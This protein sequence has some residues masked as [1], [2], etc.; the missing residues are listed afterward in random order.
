MTY[1]GRHTADGIRLLAHLLMTEARGVDPAA[2]K[3]AGW[4]MPVRGWL[5]VGAALAA[6][7]PRR[8]LALLGDPVPEETYDDLVTRT[9]RTAAVAMDVNWSPGGHVGWALPPQDEAALLQSMDGTHARLTI[10]AKDPG[11]RLPAFLAGRYLPDVL[12]ARA[13]LGSGD[14][15]NAQSAAVVEAVG[16][17]EET[18]EAVRWFDEL[19]QEIAE[20]GLA[21][22]AAYHL[23]VAADIRDRAGQRRQGEMKRREALRLA[24]RAPALAGMSELAAGDAELGVA[25]AS[26]R[27]LIVPAGG[28]ALKRAAKH[29]ARADALFL[30]SGAARGRAA[31]ALRLAH[32]ARLSRKPKLRTAYVDRALALAAVAGDGAY[33]ALLTVH[34]MLDAVEDG[35]TLPVHDADAVRHWASTVGSGSWLRG[36][37][38]LVAEGAGEWARQGHILRGRQADD[39][40]QRLTERRGAPADPERPVTDAV[41]AART[42]TGSLE[43][44]HEA[45]HR[46][47]SLVVADLE[48]DTRMRRMQSEEWE[49]VGADGP[50]PQAADLQITAG[51]VNE[52]LAAA[53]TAELFF[54]AAVGLGDPDLVAAARPRLAGVIGLGARLLG[55]GEVPPPV[56]EALHSSLEGL[57]AG[58]GSTDIVETLY[59]LRRHRSAGL[60]AEADRTAATAGVLVRTGPLSPARCALLVEMGRMAQARTEAAELEARGLLTPLQSAALRLRLREPARAA[61][62][63]RRVG[64]DGTQPDRPWERAAIAAEAS[65]ALGDRRRAAGRAAEAVTA[66]E[67]HR[68]RLG[69]DTLRAASGDDPV[70]ARAYH[71]AMLSQ[72]E[73]PDGKAAAFA[74]AERSRAGFL[75]A[76]QALESVAGQPAAVR[77]VRGWLQAESRWAARFEETAVAL[78][79]GGSGG[80]AQVPEPAVTAD[81]GSRQR[82]ILDAERALSA[83]ESEVRRI[84][85]R[86]LASRR[87]PGAVPDVAAVRSALAPDTVLLQYH[88]LDHDLLCWAVTREGLVAERHERSADDLVATARRF[89]TACA[90]G[91]EV[92]GPGR[93]LSEALLGFCSPLLS[94]YGRIVVVPPAP[95][96]LVPFHALPRAGAVLGVTHEVSYLP[97]AS[98]LTRQGHRLVQPVW[99]EAPALLVGA[100]ATAPE[101]GL[102]H[103]PGTETEVAAIHG[104]LPRSRVVTG[105]AADR[106]RVLE[107]AAGCA[108]LHLATHGDVQELTPYLSRLALAGRDHLGV[109]DLLGPGLAPELIVLSACD[110]GR[111]TATAGGDVLGL[112]RA[113][114][115][116]GARHAV[117]SLWPVDDITGCLVVTYMYRHLVSP[118]RP[119]VGT[120]LARAQR[121]VRRLSPDGREE[122]Y[123]RLADRVHVGSDPSGPCVRSRDSGPRPSAAGTDRLHPFHWAPFIHVGV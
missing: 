29:Y 53:S 11:L 2:V 73:L 31:A 66:F 112:T 118:D 108:I 70:V 22:A 96:S 42:T 36:M 94:G 56:A 13:V 27:R 115:I 104:L 90:S 23:L 99:A 106:A 10:L 14:V 120:A 63:E 98:L 61:E 20:G 41:R 44:Y 95:L 76:V 68:V 45:R 38:H 1:E 26:E 107:Q 97:A 100:P 15:I 85:P 74:T 77:A 9:L 92:A 33:G 51:M 67:E 24:S 49:A 16:G 39:L 37:A 7:E 58:L 84:A 34:R 50:G 109:D 75:D 113:A 116:S 93:V 28:R 79:G 89:H 46:L 110:T 4:A 17:A 78:R 119:P 62:A 88:L 18:Q 123:A 103:L 114:V 71:T 117:V 43:T 35:R 3:P 54:G 65:L 48:L 60:S 19:P 121:D 64:A 32:V 57:R 80:A 47:A 12:S 82:R 81:A 102:A 5:T 72:W 52:W 59:R 122:E 6:G 91:G 105:R 21:A 8:A 40:A 55:G 30:S 87:S 69:R 83:A 25:G 111:G 101:R 86:A